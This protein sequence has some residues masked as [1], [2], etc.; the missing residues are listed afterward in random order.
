MTTNI[1]SS[2][3]MDLDDG[4]FELESTHLRKRYTGWQ[5]AI[6]DYFKFD[7]YKYMDRIIY[8]LNQCRLIISAIYLCN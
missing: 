2:V 4:L 6:A 1:I 5:G 3:F 7:E 8:T